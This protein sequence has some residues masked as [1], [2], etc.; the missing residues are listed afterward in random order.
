MSRRCMRIAVP[1]WRVMSSPLNRIVP[2]V[3]S[4]RRMMVRPSVDLPQLDSPTRPSVSP[5]LMSRS[6]PSTARTWATVRWR[7]PD[8]TGN[9]VFRPRTDTSGSEAVHARV[10]CTCAVSGTLVFRSGIS[11]PRRGLGG[12]CQGADEH[13]RER[14]AEMRDRTPAGGDAGISEAR[15]TRP[16]NW[17]AISWTEHLQFYP[18]LRDPARGKLRFAYQLQGRYVARTPE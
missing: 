16:M 3:G 14:I 5:F 1:R 8:D 6:T 13:V 4:G 18:R 10:S 12:R 15:P 17:R 2:A 9:Q 7:M 11:S